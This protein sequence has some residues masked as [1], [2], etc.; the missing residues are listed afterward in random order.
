[1]WECLA[2]RQKKQ[3]DLWTTFHAQSLLGASLLGQQKYAA[4]EPL[5]RQ[6]YKG[7]RQRQAT[8]SATSKSQLTEA[9]ERLVQLYDAMGQN[10]KADAWRKKL[11]E[12]KGQEKQ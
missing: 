2:L 10:E 8:V 4:A 5:L 3:A 6:G 1:M 9:L 11:Q 7:M 12:A